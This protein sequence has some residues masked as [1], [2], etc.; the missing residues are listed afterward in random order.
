MGEKWYFIV[1]LVCISIIAN[2][3]EPLF[4]K[5]FLAT[6]VS[7]SE[8]YLFKPSPNFYKVVHLFLIDL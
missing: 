3:F 1:V 2:E 6:Y 5:I 8:K 7:S 4:K